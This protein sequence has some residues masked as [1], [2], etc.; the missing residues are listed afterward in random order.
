MDLP[1]LCRTLQICT[2]G[3]LLGRLEYNTVVVYY[4]TFFASK[5]FQ[6]KKHKMPSI[7]G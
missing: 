4:L 7:T 5:F 3:V 1:N 2:E 6:G